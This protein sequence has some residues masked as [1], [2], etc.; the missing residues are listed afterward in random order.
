MKGIFMSFYYT[1][2]PFLFYSESMKL[3]FENCPVPAPSP[4]GQITFCNKSQRATFLAEEHF[5]VGADQGASAFFS[6][7]S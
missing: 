5:P 2:M 4:S 7:R 6:T 1:S 3:D